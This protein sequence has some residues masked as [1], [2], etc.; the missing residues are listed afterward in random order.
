MIMDG[1][2][3]N[4]RDLTPKQKVIKTNS[5]YIGHIVLTQHTLLSTCMETSLTVTE[6]CLEKNVLRG[7]TLK[8]N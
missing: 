4:Q 6:L 2:Q 5:Y 1:R 8:K 3:N 7:I